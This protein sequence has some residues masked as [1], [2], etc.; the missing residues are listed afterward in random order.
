MTDF[1]AL[2]TNEINFLVDKPLPPKNLSSLF[3]PGI[4]EIYSTLFNQCN[5]PSFSMV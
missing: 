4:S 5:L 2:L 3:L 1:L